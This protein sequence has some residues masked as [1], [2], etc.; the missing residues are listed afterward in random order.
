M[1]LKNKNQCCGCAACADICPKGAIKMLE[2]VEGF[3]YPHIDKSKCIHCGLC[4]KICPTINVKACDSILEAY[5]AYNQDEAIRLNSSSGGVFTNLAEV[6]LMNDGVVY[7]AA[8]DKN[9]EVNH[10]KITKK[11]D[12]KRLRGSKYAVSYTHLTLPTTERV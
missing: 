7:G 3:Y 9:F 5:A 10:I 4:E 12:L 11:E 6:I 1:L 2:D 8:F